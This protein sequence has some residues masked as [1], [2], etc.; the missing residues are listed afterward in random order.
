MSE[1]IRIS[2]ANGKYTILLKD[3]GGGMKF[4]RNSEPWE[5]A[6]RDFAHV[7]FIRHMAIELNDARKPADK[8]MTG[9]LT[10]PHELL[11]K[12]ERRLG[13]MKMV[14]DRDDLLLECAVLIKGSLEGLAIPAK[15]LDPNRPL[16]GADGTTRKAHYGYGKQPW[17]DAVDDGAGPGGAYLMVLKYLRRDKRA[18]H[19][20]ESAR[21]YYSQM[22]MRS[23]AEMSRPLEV[24]AQ[25][26][27]MLH[28]LEEKLTQ[29]ERK[30]IR[31]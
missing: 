10:P 5:A 26:S 12:L 30:I 20:V 11:A 22:I 4:L 8:I 15:L 31:G 9:P 13:S 25:W 17:D 23:A 7:N 18:E 29:E 3:N 14:G 27:D 1:I 6:D 2:I 19:S 28:K 16:P 24:N 21:W